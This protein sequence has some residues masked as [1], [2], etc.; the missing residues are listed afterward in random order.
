MRRKILRVLSVQVE[1]QNIPRQVAKQVP[2]ENCQNVPKEE[3]KKVIFA[4]IIK[5]LH[6]NLISDKKHTTVNCTESVSVNLQLHLV[7]SGQH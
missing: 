3:C 7:L 5:K 2:V 1:C 4:E 6:A